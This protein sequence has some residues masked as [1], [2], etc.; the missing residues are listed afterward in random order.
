MALADYLPV[1]PDSRVAR[2]IARAARRYL[3]RFRGFSYDFVE[4]GEENI[5]RRLSPFP[6]RTVFDCGANL[7]HWSALAHNFFPQAA[8]HTFEPSPTNFACLH[9]KLQGSQ[10]HHQNLALS[11]EAGTVALKDYG[12][13][14]PLN[15]TV[16]QSDLHDAHSPAKIL[17]IP[18]ETGD[19]YCAKMGITMIDF[20]K[21]DVEGAE[22][23][24]LQGFERMLRHSAVGA[25]QFE[26]GYANGDAHFLMKDFFLLFSSF[27]YRVAKVRKGLLRF[28]AFQYE[29]N[30]FNSGPN[31]LAVPASRS[32]FIQ[33]LTR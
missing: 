27:G 31:Y 13:G 3:H 8:F 24:V 20:L 16:I 10:F 1:N 14:S 5:L 18:A 25:I 33:A 26:Y 21:I 2:E 6:I 9:G 15:T 7:G 23:L 4:G 17:Q 12:P 28:K 11:R 19:A 30:D 29:M 22:H 32:E